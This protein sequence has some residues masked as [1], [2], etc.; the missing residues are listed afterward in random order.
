M[1]PKVIIDTNVW[2]SGLFWGGI[3]FQV[4]EK[5]Y[6]RSVISCFSKETFDEWNDKVGI[7]AQITGKLE[8]YL[9][10]KRL[11][12]KNSLFV[13]PKEKIDICRD[14][15]DNKFLEAA[16]ASEA[17]FL[18]SGDRDLVSLKK[19]K[20]TRIITPAKFLKSFP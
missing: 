1:T 5:F 6:K 18:I 19:I 12:E 15:K 4:L 17:N 16:I 10:D 14:P 8:L 7:L 20:D 13:F 2:I 9:K 11:I 3:P